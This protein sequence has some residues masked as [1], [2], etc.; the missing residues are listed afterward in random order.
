MKSH[1]TTIIDIAHKLNLSKSTVS[2][3]LT[4]H[5]N[6]KAETRQAIQALA[7]EMDY[8]RNMFWNESGVG[9]GQAGAGGKCI[10]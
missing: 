5:P 1:Q 4:G 3:A 9:S 7:E 6:V 10:E 2:R 8:Q